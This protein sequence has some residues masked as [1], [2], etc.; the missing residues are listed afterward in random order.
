MWPAFCTGLSSVHCLPPAG[1]M[2]S[3]VLDI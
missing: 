2:L 3:A 1:L